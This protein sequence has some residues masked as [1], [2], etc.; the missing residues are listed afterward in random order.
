MWLGPFWQIS[1]NSLFNTF[2]A[3]PVCTPSESPPRITLFWIV[4]PEGVALVQ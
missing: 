3:V 1:A 2:T 4:T